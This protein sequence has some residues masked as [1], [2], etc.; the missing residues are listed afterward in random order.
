MSELLWA[1]LAGV[2]TTPAF[3]GGL[4]WTLVR[5]DRRCETAPAQPRVSQHSGVS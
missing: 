4:V 2:L 1:Y 3:C 5:L